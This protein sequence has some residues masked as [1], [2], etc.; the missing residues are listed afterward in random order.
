M[1]PRYA[2]LLLLA[3]SCPKLTEVTLAKDSYNPKVVSLND[4]T[5]DKVARHLLSIEVLHLI[6]DIRKPI[7][8]RSIRSLGRYCLK[9]ED[10]ALCSIIFDWDELSNRPEG[11]VISTSIWV[12]EVTLHDDQP[13]LPFNEPYEEYR[14]DSDR[15]AELASNFAH[16]FPKLASF[17]LT[18]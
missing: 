5:M 18:G 7:T 13:L 4:D 14:R 8:L 6:V 12:M 11:D 10:L 15:I 3:Q 1:T 16:M 9:L 17:S 2:T